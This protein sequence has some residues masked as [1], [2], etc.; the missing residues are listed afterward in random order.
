MRGDW[1]E[2]GKKRR[3]WKPKLFR[4]EWKASTWTLTVKVAMQGSKK[5][6]RRQSDAPGEEG[7]V[8]KSPKRKI[9]GVES[10]ETQDYVREANDMD[11]EEGEEISFETSAICVPQKPSFR[12]DNQCSE[13]TFS[14]WQLASVVIKEGDESYT[15]N[16]CQKSY[17]EC[18]KAKGDEPL[19][20][21][22]WH[23]FVEKKGAPWK[24]LENV[25]K[26][27]IRTRHVGI[28]VP[29]TS[30][31]KTVSRGGRRR[32]ASRKT[33][34]VALGIASQRVFGAS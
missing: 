7:E 5:N 16:S 24:T 28:S 1:N 21:W 13:Q 34:S 30:K 18:L 12:G 27:T 14:F 15:T 8:I 22:Q 26:R 33:G 3:R 29:R 31:I 11:Q 6:F 10:E 4:T 23:E 9:I 32:K 19:T 17:H 25:G 2:K 20:K